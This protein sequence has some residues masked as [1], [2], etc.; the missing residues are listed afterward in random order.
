MLV[1]VGIAGTLLP[2]LPGTPLVFGGLLL[3][4][5]VDGFQNV[6]VVTVIVLAVLTVLAFCVDFIS[7]SLGARGVGASR[8]AVVGAAL[9]TLVGIFFGFAGII[10]GPFIGAVTG[11]FMARRNLGQAGRAGIATWIGFVLGIGV[12]LM[13]AFTMVGIFFLAYIF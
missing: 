12:K 9:G 10:L 3:A 7:S 4:A 11:E 2:G 13:L 5:W 6:S 8:G 1:G